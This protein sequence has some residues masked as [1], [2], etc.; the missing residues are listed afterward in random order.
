[1]QIEKSPLRLDSNS[2]YHDCCFA[3]I[4]KM[5]GAGIE[6]ITLPPYVPAKCDEPA[7]A[8]HHSLLHLL[9]EL[10]LDRDFSGPWSPIVPI[11]PSSHRA[12]TGPPILLVQR[13][14]AYFS[15][16]PFTM[17]R[18]DVSILPNLCFTTS[19]DR[20]PLPA[21]SL[22]GTL[23]PGDH[24]TVGQFVSCYLNGS[25]PT[26][27]KTSHPSRKCFPTEKCVALRSLCSGLNTS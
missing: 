8:L 3:N 11:V 15:P 17:S 7:S 25:P 20:R 6:A 27:T 12:S 9:T 16:S 21:L 19:C 22:P 13:G 23:I 4:R 14:F 2:M 10:R 26:D 18:G 24:A 5:R 1:M